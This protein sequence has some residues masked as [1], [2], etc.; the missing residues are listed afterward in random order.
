MRCADVRAMAESYLAGELPVDTNH[1]IL[2]H[3]ERCASCQAEVQARLALRQ[4]LRDAFR[5]SRDLAPDPRFTAQ[6]QDL[7]SSHFAPR[8]ARGFA[9]R[10]WLA[11]AAAVTVVAV[12]GWQ[13]LGGRAGRAGFG[14]LA[15]L[16]AI[17]AGDHRFCALQHALDEAPITLAEAASRFDPAYASLE[18][19][20]AGASPVRDGDV[21]VLGA[22]SCLFRGRR[23]AHVILRRDGRVV[24][25]LLTPLEPRQAAA[26]GR[27]EPCPSSNGF[28]IACFV[29]GDHAGFVVSDLTESGNMALAT[30]LAP[31]LQTHFGRG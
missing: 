19:A 17:A 22:H 20:V 26:P 15:E 28:R 16:A 24:S 8:P 14:H 4:S 7:V 2:A 18:E 6:V 5:S 25:I 30:E 11:I 31:V 10:R 23:F 13:L 3:L 1:A 27:V 21:E 9:S 29:A 12:A